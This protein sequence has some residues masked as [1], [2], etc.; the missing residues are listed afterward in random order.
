VSGYYALVVKKVIEISLVFMQSFV[1]DINSR[2]FKV[3]GC[4]GVS[5]EIIAN[6]GGDISAG[7]TVEAEFR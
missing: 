4:K 1:K 7:A 3:R 6:I 2:N 5:D